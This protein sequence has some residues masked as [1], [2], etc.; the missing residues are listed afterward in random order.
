M[1]QIDFP[2]AK[3]A[4]RTVLV[5]AL[6]FDPEVYGPLSETSKSFLMAELK[7]R[8]MQARAFNDVDLSDEARS[9]GLRH[10]QDP[11]LNLSPEEDANIIK[12][13]LQLYAS[14]FKATIGI[15]STVHGMEEPAS[16]L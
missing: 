4:A 3:K 8:M 10:S 16:V 14:Y 15:G 12:V 6:H 1:P 5:I 13:A 9:V 11:L 2:Y 7:E